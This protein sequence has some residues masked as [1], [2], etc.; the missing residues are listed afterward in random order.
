VKRGRPPA[1][2]LVGRYRARGGVEHRVA[3]QRI[4]QGGWLVLDGGTVVQTLLDAG[5]GAR[6]AQ[7]VALDYA[8]EKQAYHD[9]RRLDDPHPVRWTQ[10]A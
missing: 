4:A 7:A 5:D 1:Y 3:I 10:A 8:T 9:G 2:A 6:Q